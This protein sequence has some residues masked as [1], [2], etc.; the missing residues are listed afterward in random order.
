MG[1]GVPNCHFCHQSSS[2]GSET[3]G[4]WPASQFVNPPMKAVEC[5]SVNLGRRSREGQKRILSTVRRLVT[6]ARMLRGKSNLPPVSQFTATARVG[7]M[8]G[9]GFVISR[10]LHRRTTRKLQAS[11][12]LGVHARDFRRRLEHGAHA[13]TL[14]LAR[15]VVATH[16]SQS[17]GWWVQRGAHTRLT[18]ATHRAALLKLPCPLYLCGHGGAEH[19]C[20]RRCHTVAHKVEYWDT[21]HCAIRPHR[22]FLPEPR[23]AICQLTVALYGCRPDYS[24][25]SYLI[26][27]YRSFSAISTWKVARAHV[28][29]RAAVHISVMSRLTAQSRARNRNFKK[30]STSMC[31]Q[32]RTQHAVPSAQKRPTKQLLLKVRRWRRRA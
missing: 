22:L 9:N 29:A 10:P 12:E 17:S 7:S 18:Q 26:D 15:A 32:S 20:S 28:H 23:S 8:R 13:P 30:R 6:A 3:A 21:F 16:T 27:I 1:V 24:R 14:Q 11:S 25:V 31:V 19:P 4:W 2:T 5:S